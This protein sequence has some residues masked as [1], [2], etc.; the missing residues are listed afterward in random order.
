M[1]WI[2]ALLFFLLAGPAWATGGWTDCSAAAT[3]APAQV[4][5]GEPVCWAHDGDDDSGL[6]EIPHGITVL[7]TYDPDITT[8]GA[9]TGQGYLRCCV[10]GASAS[11]ALCPPTTGTPFTGAAGDDGPPCVG[12]NQCW[13]QE[14]GAGQCFWETT[15]SPGGDDAVVRF[16]AR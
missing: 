11:T 16:E 2:I 10:S 1:G 3:A 15:T 8:D 6:I 7:V 9:A 13:A 12:S 4:V 14:V 5:R